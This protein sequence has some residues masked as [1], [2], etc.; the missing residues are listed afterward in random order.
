[1]PSF[2]KYPIVFVTGGSAY[3]LLE[4]AFRG[5]TH[6]SM[7]IAGGVCFIMMYLI[8]I[9]SRCSMLKKWIMGGAV[10]TAVEFITGGIVNIR[11]GWNVWDYSGHPLN[12]MGQI[13][14]LFSMIWVLLSIPGMWLCGV[15]EN[16]VFHG[17]NRK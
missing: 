10:V 11:L 14:A 2:I 12:L 7:L 8:R 9:K 15:L 6:W 16:G 5:K 13:C 1:M 3:G 17:E 4:I